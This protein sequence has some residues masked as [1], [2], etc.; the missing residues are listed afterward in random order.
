MY[1]DPG[2]NLTLEQGKMIKA[3][4][5]AK[6]VSR[7]KLAKEVNI[8]TSYVHRIETHTRG[9]VSYPL[10]KKIAN[11]LDTDVLTLL[12]EEI[13]KQKKSTKDKVAAEEILLS[14]DVTVWEEH[15]MPLSELPYA[16]YYKP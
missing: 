4:R 12:G 7:A 5:E 14:R 16:T 1:K 8:S 3:Y 15:L 2:K 6:G 10:I 11:A 13:P 9:A